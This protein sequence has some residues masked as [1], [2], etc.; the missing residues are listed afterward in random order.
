[1]T[2]ERKEYILSIFRS[3]KQNKEYLKYESLKKVEDMTVEERSYFED[4]KKKVDVVD[5]ILFS[6]GLDDANK[7]NFVIGHLINGQSQKRVSFSCYVSERTLRR[8]N[9]SVYLS[10]DKCLKILGM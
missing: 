8:W 7:K 3:Y 10:I 6:V 1:M 9:E 5:K 2:K 4:L